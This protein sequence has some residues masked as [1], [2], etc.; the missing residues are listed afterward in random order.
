MERDGLISKSL[1]AYSSPVML[2]TKHDGSKRVVVD[3]RKINSVL[4]DEVF[5]SPTLQEVVEKVGAAKARVYSLIDLRAAYNQIVIAKE[6]RKY[7]AF[8]CSLGNFEYCRLPFG[9]KLSGNYFNYLVNSAVVKD[10]VLSKSIITFI[11]DLFLFTKTLEEHLNIM[12]RLFRVLRES[13]LKIHNK[14]C[15]LLQK[16]VHFIGHIFGEEGVEP[17]PGKI[18]AMQNF[19][20]PTNKKSLKSFLGLISYY[21]TFIKNLSHDFSRL[22]ELLRK[23][24][25]YEWTDEREKAFQRIK[26]KLKKLPTLAYVDESK[27]APPLILQ[28][29]ASNKSIAGVLSQKTRDGKAEKLIACYG[30]NLRDNELAWDIGHKEI[31]AMIIGIIKFRHIIA[32]KKLIVR[33][34][35][36]SVKYFAQIKGSSNARLVRWNLY[37]SDILCNTTFEYVQGESNFVDALS[38]RTY[39][40]D[41]GSTEREL[42]IVHD[43]LT[44]RAMQSVED[45]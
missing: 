28:T 38:R 9:L 35:N 29:D 25:K 26:Q 32:G 22:L 44:I 16:K 12:E 21:R 31:L 40:K 30:R 17:E 15:S 5:P 27:D 10:E 45:H 8:S 18:D 34:D 2:V 14:K 41:E 3:M 4:Q 7:T 11:D 37:L 13:D 33:S 43:D 24:V 23:G 6:S 39:E 20:R 1:S 42:D 36:L 19:P